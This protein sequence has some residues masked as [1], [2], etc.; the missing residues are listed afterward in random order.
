MSL[1]KS[2]SPRIILGLMN[3]G[4][5]VNAGGRIT[6]LDEFNKCLDLLQQRGYNEIDTAR[7]Y[8]DGKQEEFTAATGWKE[9]RDLTLATKVY[10]I[11][12][13][14]HRREILRQ[15]LSESLKALQTDSVD[16][17]YLHAADRSVPF[18]ETLEA[19][20]EMYREGKFRRLGLSNYAA[21]EIAE[22][23]TM[24]NE[25]GWVRPVI[26]QAMYNAISKLLFQIMILV[27]GTR[28]HLYIARTDIFS[29]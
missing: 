26:Y 22:I 23:V 9:K 29:F 13:G 6:T 17:F 16:I 7:L 21:F 24:C 8:M 3:F 15:Q 11:Q 14:F 28:L 18:A 4:P 20:D 19:V 27:L 25:R 1:T 12:P 5:D 10:P 2:S